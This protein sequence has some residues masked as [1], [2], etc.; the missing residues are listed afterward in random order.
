[1][2]WVAIVQNQLL[3]PNTR[4]TAV[5]GLFKLNTIVDSPTRYYLRY[6]RVFNQF[7][8]ND[9]AENRQKSSSF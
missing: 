8:N 7:A 9:S 1:M 6:G 5:K 4:S 3:S 2:M